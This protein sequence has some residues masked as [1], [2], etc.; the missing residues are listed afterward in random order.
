MKLLLVV[1]EQIKKN[2]EHAQPYNIQYTCP[3]FTLEISDNIC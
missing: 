1:N 3:N 2:S